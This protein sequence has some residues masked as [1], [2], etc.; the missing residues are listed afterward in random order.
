MG[1][2]RYIALLVKFMDPY[3]A[4]DINGCYEINERTEMSLRLQ[5]DSLRHYSRPAYMEGDFIARRRKRKEVEHQRRMSGGMWEEDENL[6]DET[7]NVL[8][9]EK[10]RCWVEV[11]ISSPMNKSRDGVAATARAKLLRRVAGLAA[12]GVSGSTDEVARVASGKTAK[13]KREALC[14]LPKLCNRGVVKGD[15]KILGLRKNSNT[16]MRR[17]LYPVTDENARPPV[18]AALPATRI[19]NAPP[20][21]PPPS[22]LRSSNG[23]SLIP[24]LQ[25]EKRV[26]TDDD[27]PILKR[28][29]MSSVGPV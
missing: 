24:V 26:H 4:A 14:E 25:R 3:V 5:K 1:E 12:K 13:R 2:K 28:Q 18:F 27:E 22:H 8:E 20:A 11:T 9:K 6:C 23:P 15:R 17:T 7:Y 16:A 29:R 10:S 19:S 21:P